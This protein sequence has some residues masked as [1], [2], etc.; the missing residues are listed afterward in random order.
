MHC[1]KHGIKNL[2]QWVLVTDRLLTEH[3]LN[4]LQGYHQLIV[5]FSGGLDSTVLLHVIAKEPSLV[6]KLQAVHIHHGLSVYA[7]AWRMHCQTICKGLSIPLIVRQVQCC[8]R[9]NIEE[10]A[11]IARY[12]AF[13]SFIN[14]N[15]A[16]V[17]AHH[18]DDQAETLLLQLFRGAGIDGMAAMPSIKTLPK[19]ELVRPFLEHSRQKL[20]SYARHHQLTWVEDESNQNGAFSRNYLRQQIMPLL[21]ER[22]PGIMVNLGRS[23][24]HCQQ[25]KL[26]LDALAEID[27][28]GLS[29]QGES[30]SLLALQ[31]H[32]PARVENIL[33][34]W[35]RNNQVR[36]PPATIL[37]RLMDEVILAR[38]DARP[39]VA[40][41][42]VAVARFQQHLYLLKNKP[43][44][45]SS[46][47]NWSDFPAPL[48]FNGCDILFASPAMTG[49]LVPPG[50]SVEIRF[51]QGGELFCWHGQTKQ[52]KKLWQQWKIPPWAR[53]QIPL[54]Y[55][56]EV[57]AAVVGFAIA[58][59][60]YSTG[61][62]N[63]YRVEKIPGET[64][65]I[66]R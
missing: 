65:M 66:Y 33:R 11:R 48:P 63:T 42:V 6:D 60:Y 7:D 64:D 18:A 57:L 34:V 23:A 44:A 36:R 59:P 39:M 13:S 38:P 16:L 53:D 62:E 4:T 52:L 28:V 46:N 26:N 55:I 30:L 10:G 47:I 51:R 32:G 40:W 21:Q 3:W 45:R 43:T 61:P 41:D 5:G 15:D 56:D 1:S 12:E 35:L 37:T 27:V 24:R 54:L 22:W 31:S 50:S 8:S 20:E 29:Q 17:L 14:D 58:D 9:A 19:G 25:A 49:L 2:W